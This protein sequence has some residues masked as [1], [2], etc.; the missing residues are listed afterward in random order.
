MYKICIYRL[1]FTPNI[2]VHVQYGSQGTRYRANCVHL[3]ILKPTSVFSFQKICYQFPIYLRC[4]CAAA[5]LCLSPRL[6]PIFSGSLSF[7]CKIS[8]ILNF[9]K[10]C[11]LLQEKQFMEGQ[12]TKCGTHR[13]STPQF[14]HYKNINNYPKL[15]SLFLIYDICQQI[16][17]SIFL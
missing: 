13:Y 1:I 15:K 3:Y 12:M 17:T 11:F 9:P 2:Y 5:V 4:S 7:H 16:G 6:C 10:T 8:F 14:F